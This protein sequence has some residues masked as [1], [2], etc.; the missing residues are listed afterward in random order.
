MLFKNHKRFI[1]FNFNDFVLIKSYNTDLLVICYFD[2]TN[3]N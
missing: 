3:E 1:E 2:H